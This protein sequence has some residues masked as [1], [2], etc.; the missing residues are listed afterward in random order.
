LAARAMATPSAPPAGY[1]LVR[2]SDAIPAAA[3]G[4]I[5]QLAFRP[6]D[7]AHLFAVRSANGSIVRFDFD[8]ASGALSNAVSV[9]TGLPDPLG[10]AFRGSDLYVS[11]NPANDSRITRLRDNDQDGVFETRSDFVRGVP[12]RD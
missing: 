9:A 1:T 10:L 5:S 2:V 3:M 11:L 7:G 4:D 6:G 8:L 12:N